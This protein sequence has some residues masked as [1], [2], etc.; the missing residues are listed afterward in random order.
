MSDMSKFN[1]ISEKLIDSLKSQGIKLD[2]P[3]VTNTI[4]FAL[5]ESYGLGEEEGIIRGKKNA[6]EQMDR[7]KSEMLRKIELD[8]HLLE[9]K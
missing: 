2:N 1:K 3:G 4:I 5:A 8:E 9:Q 7:L 6:I